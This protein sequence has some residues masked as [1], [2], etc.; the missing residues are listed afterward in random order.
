MNNLTIRLKGQTDSL[1]QAVQEL[2]GQLG[3]ILKETGT[4]VKVI[5]RK[6]PLEVKLEDG[7]GTIAYEAP[8]HFFRGL[9]LFVEQAASK[10]SFTIV[11]E[12]RFDFNGPMLDVSRNAVLK[13]DTVKQFIRYMALMGLNG[14]MLYTEDTYE[15]ESRPY[16]GYMRGRY[17]AAE[18]KE[19]DDYAD[20]FGIEVVPC[21]Q[22][23][24]HLTQALKWSYAN[25]IK[26]QDDILLIGEPETYKFIEDMIASASAPFRSKRI[27][28]GMDEAFSVGLGRYLA[29]NGYR[30]RF[31]MMME[32]MKQVLDITAKYGLKPM[33]WSDMI[34]HFLSNDPN[35]F[36]YPLDVNFAKDKLELLPEGLDYV[37]WCYGTREQSKYETLIQKHRELGSDPIFAGGI[38]IWGSLSPNYG[39]TWMITHPALQACKKQ[40][41]REVLATAWGDNGQETNHLLMLPGLQLFAEHGYADDVT[42]DKL[43][44]RLKTCAGLDLFDAVVK[45][46]EL[47]ETPGVE[48]GNHFMANPSKYLLWQDALLGLFDKHIEGEA[49]EIL[50]EHY[51]SLEQFCREAGEG[52]PEPF[53]L[54]FSFYEQ[55]SGVLTYK[56]TLGLQLKRLY[57]AGSKDGLKKMAE[58]NLPALYQKVDALRRAHRKLWMTTYKPQGWEVLDIRYGGL[59]A[60]LSTACDRITDYVQ[61]TVD[62]LEE[63]EEERLLFDP[64]S[65]GITIN[66]PSY[67]R[68][69][70]P[71]A[72]N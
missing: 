38:H 47:D 20:M 9:G 13:I 18:L 64:E 68:I 23:L 15:I 3:L 11:E 22:T 37:Y 33:I 27:H 55:L 57:L 5:C 32:H 60:R 40:G 30:E 53:N 36:H 42:D 49:E 4:P 10:D 52:M 12:P 71:G 62:R 21:I 69:A 41:V 45:L 31:D 17:S 39:K 63:L 1:I 67:Q 14:L 8:H 16:F 43:R 65:P 59:L 46:K 51:G 72:M 2:T 35:G 25:N 44:E 6:G 29:K 48:A 24:A 61:G 7:E 56:A 50:S 26:D 70:T 66:V 34:F 58:V 28:I 54:V 19:I